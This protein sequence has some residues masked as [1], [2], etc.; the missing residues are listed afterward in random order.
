M[1][2]EESKQRGRK[3]KTADRKSP[4]RVWVANQKVTRYNQLDC[5]DTRGRGCI[6]KKYDLLN[7]Q[8]RKGERRDIQPKCEEGGGK[9]K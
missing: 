7:G 1:L 5:G 3:C 9:E 8:I 4:F 6:P 2:S